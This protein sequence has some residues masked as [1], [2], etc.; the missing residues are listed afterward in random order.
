MEPHQPNVR[1]G[2]GGVISQDGPAIRELR[3]QRKQQ[4]NEAAAGI[5]C[6][7]KYLSQLERGVRSASDVM[8]QQIADYYRVPRDQ[9]RRRRDQIRKQPEVANAA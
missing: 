1:L 8:L 2:R 3:V 6:H 9:L 7:A 5:G 4:I